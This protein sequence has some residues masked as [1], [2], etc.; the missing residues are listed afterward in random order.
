MLNKTLHQALVAL[1][2][3]LS[4]R[5]PWLY[6]SLALPSVVRLPF[7]GFS[8]FRQQQCSCNGMYTAQ[9]LPR[10][11]GRS[12]GRSLDGQ[13]VGLLLAVLTCCN[14]RYWQGEWKSWLGVCSCTHTLGNTALTPGSGTGSPARRPQ[15]RPRPPPRTR[16][17]RPSPCSPSPV[18]WRCWP[19]RGS[20]TCSGRRRRV[21][22]P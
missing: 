17:A 7:R 9:G 5:A 18:R 20:P 16:W 11:G 1:Y 14:L 4:Y 21:P 10:G 8:R 13:S 19:P 12:M 22:R 2:T 15:G 6:F 3:I